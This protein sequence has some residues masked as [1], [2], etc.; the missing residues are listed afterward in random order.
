METILLE[1]FDMND[2]PANVRLSI[3]YVSKHPRSSPDREQLLSRVTLDRFRC[4]LSRAARGGK[5]MARRGLIDDKRQEE[6]RRDVP[7]DDLD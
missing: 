2:N 5:P 4:H 7:S 6:A 1:K 3:L